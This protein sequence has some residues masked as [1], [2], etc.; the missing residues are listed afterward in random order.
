[1]WTYTSTSC[2][3][4][5]RVITMI[6]FKGFYGFGR[7]LSILCTAI[8]LNLPGILI[9]LVNP[10]NTKSIP[11]LSLDGTILLNIIEF[12]MSQCTIKFSIIIPFTAFRVI[13][14]Y[15]SFTWLFFVFIIVI[16]LERRSYIKSM[17]LKQGVRSTT[18]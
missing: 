15:L 12:S 10:M 16:R 5:F 14:S 7:T 3:N 1:M 2:L 9:N 11:I 8:L 17:S 13:G 6:W 18:L 4:E